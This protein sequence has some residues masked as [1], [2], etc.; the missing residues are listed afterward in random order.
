[1][2]SSRRS[3]FLTATLILALLVMGYLWYSYVQSRPPS[4]VTSVGPASEVG[5]EFLVLLKTLETLKL[6]L[7]FF[8][9]PAFQSL[10][11]GG[12]LPP[13]PQETASRGRSN[14]FAPLK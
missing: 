5:Q 8:S 10:K 3:N 9:A 1:M 6:D 13:L 7:S 11:T 12:A 14:P 4:A 2:S